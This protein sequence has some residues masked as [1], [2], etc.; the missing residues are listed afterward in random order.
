LVSIIVLNM[1][2]E[3]LRIPL[4]AVADEF[5]D[6][7]LS[8]EYDKDG[9]GPHVQAHVYLSGLLQQYGVG[10][11]KDGQVI[12]MNAYSPAGFTLQCPDVEGLCEGSG[13][14]TRISLYKPLCYHPLEVPYAVR[15]TEIVL[16]LVRVTGLDDLQ[17]PKQSSIRSTDK[18]LFRE[19]ENSKGRVVNYQIKAGD[20]ER[21]VA[22]GEV[23]AQAYAT[24]PML[25]RLR[26]PDPRRFRTH[27]R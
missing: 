9:W 3:K 13:L 8:P 27:R 15:S 17:I 26:R 7:A 18:Y 1:K 22:I 5:M 21:I 16:S 6:A 12:D 11:G 2:L 20:P 14:R 19:D 25:A 24:S 23:L 10:V 4:P